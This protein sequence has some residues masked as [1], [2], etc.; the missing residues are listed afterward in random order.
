MDQKASGKRVE[1]EQRSGA[2][3]RLIVTGTDGK[4][5]TLDLITHVVAVEEL[6]D[7]KRPD[8]R[9]TF[10]FKAALSANLLTDEDEQ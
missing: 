2:P 9:P 7:A 4:Q 10:Q 8:G 6:P 5:Y 1:F 3:H